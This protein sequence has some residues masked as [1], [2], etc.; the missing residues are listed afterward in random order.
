L[1]EDDRM[2]VQQ[3]FLVGGSSFNSLKKTLEESRRIE[4]KLEF[5]DIGET[6]PESYPVLLDMDQYCPLD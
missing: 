3:L 2:L 6:R 5:L 1:R 4:F